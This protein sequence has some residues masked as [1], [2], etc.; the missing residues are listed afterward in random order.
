MR[1]LVLLSMLV[2]HVH[3]KVETVTFEDGQKV[4]FEL[5]TG[6]EYAKDLYGMPLVIL[7]PWKNQARP[8]LSILPTSFT[9]KI[10]E[11]DSLKELFIGFKNKKKVGLN[12]TKDNSFLSINLKV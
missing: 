5:P 2:M 9:K 7:G 6:W 11:P 1:L 8:A 3:A 4:S 12:H 10:V